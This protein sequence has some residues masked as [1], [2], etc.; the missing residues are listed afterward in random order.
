MERVICC[1][2]ENPIEGPVIEMGKRPYCSVC[3]A[4]VL[5]NRGSVW[6]ASLLGIGILV[7]F[8]GLVAL[9]VGAAKP[10]LSGA[11]LVFWGIVLALI[12]AL[13]WLAVFYL[14][15]VREPEPKQ[16]VIG[17]FILGIIIARAVGLPLVQSVFRVQDWLNNSTLYHILGSI[18]VIGFIQQFLIYAVVRYSVY[19]AGE[20]DERVDGVVYS[21]AAAL[22]Y[23][24]MVNLQYVVDSGGVDLVNGIMRIAVTTM[25]LASFGGLMGYFLGRCKFEDEPAWWMPAGLTL[26]AILNGLFRYFLGE[27]TTTKVGLEGGGYNPVWGLI[28]G[29]V[30]AVVTTVVLYLMIRRLQQRA[31]QALGA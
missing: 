9:I 16:L 6:W 23:A 14:Q 22:G 26:A 25:A 11:G 31:P 28:W 27:I 19:N 30:V 20:F 17:V 21:T 1:V 13:I 15:D 7:V 18:L 3:H 29:T 12:P 2:C 8:V 5:R 24:T 4:K 10:E